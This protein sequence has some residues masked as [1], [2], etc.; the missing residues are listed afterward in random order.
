MHKTL[1]ALALAAG[2]LGATAALAENTVVEQRAKLDRAFAQDTSA[3]QVSRGSDNLF[4]RT[5][6]SVSFGF[7]DDGEL[8]ANR[9]GWSDN[10]RAGRV[11]EPAGR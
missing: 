6:G 2:A 11:H 7:I 5:F 9:G 10:F 3:R 1:A 8:R 4:S